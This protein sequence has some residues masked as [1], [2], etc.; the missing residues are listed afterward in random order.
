MADKD[1]EEVPYLRGAKGGG[2]DF[3]LPLVIVKVN[4][5]KCRPEERLEQIPG[6]LLA[7]ERL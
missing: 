7:V 4:H 2:H 6:M 3:P 5:A 1:R